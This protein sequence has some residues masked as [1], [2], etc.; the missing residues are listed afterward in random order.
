MKKR[1]LI[2]ACL[3]LLLFVSAC[4]NND[5]Q[6]TALTSETSPAEV[7][8]LHL[9]AEATNDW[10]LWLSTI[11]EERQPDFTDPDLYKYLKSLTITEVFEITGKQVEDRKKSILSSE[12]GQKNNLNADNI[13]F[14]Y[15][16]FTVESDTT[17]SPYCGTF[18][19]VYTLYRTDS[20]SPW[21]IQ[22]WGQGYFEK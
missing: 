5:N 13:A 9:K 20:N 7:V 22:D 8:T 14:V 10:N 16:D 3:C 18:Q 6:T 17:K 19:W 11:T 1:I 15:A 4:Q 2:T 21:L 12:N